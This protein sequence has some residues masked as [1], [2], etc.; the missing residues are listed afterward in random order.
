MNDPLLRIAL[1]VHPV[2]GLLA[3]ALAVQTAG[4]ALRG[5]RPGRAAAAQLARH[6]RLGPWLLGLVIVTWIGGVVSVWFDPRDVEL[7]ASGHFQ[8]GTLVV[9]LFTVAALLSRR[10]DD[11]P[12]VRAIHPWVGAAALLASGVQVF[13]G[14]QLIGW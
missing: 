13:L 3:V 7:A 9:V 11:D 1:W 10:I 5:R 12:R 8:V 4:Y 14:L 2:M 6:R